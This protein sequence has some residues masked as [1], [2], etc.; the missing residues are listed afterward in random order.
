MLCR[1]S[2]VV[3]AIRADQVRETM[4]PLPLAAL[5]DV[6]PFVL[7]IA[8]IRGAPTPVVDAQ[9]LLGKQ[10]SPTRFVTLHAGERS[11][12]MAFDA[13]VGTRELPGATL[14][15][16]PPLVN[17]AVSSFVEA[18]GVLD[19]DLLLVLQA[20]RVVPERVWE[21]LEGVVG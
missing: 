6:P 21:G 15:T 2:D 3:I 5:P 9:R 17:A 20:A 10:G 18:V 14:T 16:L 19:E 13:V 1:A 12:A 8:V 11:V 7:G 4:R